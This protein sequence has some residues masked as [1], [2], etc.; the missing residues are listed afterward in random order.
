MCKRA[1]L[2]DLDV[3]AYIY[4]LYCIMEQ[5]PVETTSEGEI[6]KQKIIYPKGTVLQRQIVDDLLPFFIRLCHEGIVV[7]TDTQEIIHVPY[8]QIRDLYRLMDTFDLQVVRTSI[9]EFAAGQPIEE[10]VLNTTKTA[11]E[12]VQA[13]TAWENKT[14]KY[15]LLFSNCETFTNLC[16]L[17]TPISDQALKMLRDYGY[18][19]CGMYNDAHHK[20]EIRRRVEE[21]EANLTD[22]QRKQKAKRNARKNQDEK[23]TILKNNFSLYQ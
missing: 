18:I 6:K 20:E 12:I 2:I 14:W 13:V 19:M 5:Q 4:L 10:K 9:D 7:D 23:N 1:T 11:A 3:H 8:L 15:H 17:D 21:R 22:K 16:A